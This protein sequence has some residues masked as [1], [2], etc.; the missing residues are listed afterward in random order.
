MESG[1]VE[2]KRG[3]NA[4]QKKSSPVQTRYNST[5]AVQQYKRA[6]SISAVQVYRRGAQTRYLALSEL[7]AVQTSSNAVQRGILLVS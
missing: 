2:L 4:V 1:D 7:K 3:T 5:S 6:T